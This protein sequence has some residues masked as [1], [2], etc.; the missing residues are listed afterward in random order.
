MYQYIMQPVCLERRSPLF[1]RFVIGRPVR[2]L[3]LLLGPAAHALSATMLA[4][5]SETPNRFAQ[6]GLIEGNLERVL[7]A[8]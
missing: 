5:S 4:S 2:G 3:V 1:Q 6:Q 7:L 8:M